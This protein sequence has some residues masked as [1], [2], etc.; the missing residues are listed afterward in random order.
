M[1]SLPPSIHPSPFHTSIKNIWAEFCPGEY[2]PLHLGSYIFGGILSGG[3]LSG[4]ILSGRNIVRGEYNPSTIDVD[5]TGIHSFGI[6]WSGQCQYGRVCFMKV[7]NSS[8]DHGSI[9]ILAL[10]NTELF[11]CT[12]HVKINVI[13]IFMKMSDF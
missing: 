9:T 10:R 3:I 1:G 4:G 13:E 2:C 6:D 8:R 5:D 11:I 12:W 7:S